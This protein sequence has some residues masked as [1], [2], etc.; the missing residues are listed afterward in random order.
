MPITP[1]PEAPHRLPVNLDVRQFVETDQRLS[2]AR[3]YHEWAA[4]QYATECCRAT[5]QLVRQL[6]P[7]SAILTFDKQE[8]IGGDTEIEL[9][10]IRGESGALLWYNDVALTT[11]PDMT[12]GCDPRLLPFDALRTI[13]SQLSEAYDTQTGQFTTSTEDAPEDLA[14]PNLLELSISDVLAADTQRREG[15]EVTVQASDGSPRHHYYLRRDDTVE[16]SFSGDPVVGIDYDGPG[17]WVGEDG[18]D[19]NRLLPGGIITERFLV[20]LGMDC[21]QY[22]RL[23]EV[24]RLPPR[25]LGKWKAGLGE[26]VDVMIDLDQLAPAHLASD[27]LDRAIDFAR[28]EGLPFREDRTVYYPVPDAAPPADDS[29]ASQPP[30]T[31]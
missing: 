11:H 26:S 1:H 25:W 8:S 14:E 29:P 4:G 2:D 15:R 31:V 3:R 12:A 22:Q 24:L 30:L 21:D 5:A 20:V 13:E 10:S 18:E 23:H 7:A 28:A 19:W 6:L 16:V 27:R 9:I 17:T